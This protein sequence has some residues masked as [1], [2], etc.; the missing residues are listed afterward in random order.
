MSS[1]RAGRK[2]RVSR[3]IVLAAATVS[4]GWVYPARSA[5]GTTYTWVNSGVSNNWTELSNWTLA[6]GSHLAPPL[7]PAAGDMTDLIF[8]GTFSANQTSTQNVGEI[9]I[10]SMT[11]ATTFSGTATLAL[12][13]SSTGNQ[14]IRLGAGGLVGNAGGTIA[15][16][17]GTN[18]KIILTADQSWSNSNTAAIISQRRTMEGAFKITKT[19][20]GTIEFQADDSAWTGGLQIND[21]WIRLS[22]FSNAIGAGTITNVS[23]S[24]TGIAASGS[25]ETI[26]NISGPVVLG[27]TGTLGL[28]G[29]WKINLQNTVTLQTDKIINVGNFS[30][31]SSATDRQI[32]G[33]ILGPGGLIKAGTGT[34][35]LSG[36]NNTYAGNTTVLNGVLSVGSLG[37]LGGHHDHARCHRARRGHDLDQLR[38]A[39]DCHCRPDHQPGVRHE[40]WRRQSRLRRG[41]HHQ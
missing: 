28:A 4:A 11:F 15:L 35:L 5:L 36:A 33:N 7:T 19:G 23:D 25:A 3:A 13:A 39:P 18:R 40:P 24:A 8:A 41:S 26:Q 2:S 20:A 30:S 21:G 10:N 37:Q 31:L 6:D 34:M 12:S 9:E 32:S 16:T 14:Y 1:M 27:G 38:H 17:G 22:N 29:S